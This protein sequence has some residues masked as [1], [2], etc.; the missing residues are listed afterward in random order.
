VPKQSLLTVCSL[1]G[2]HSGQEALIGVYA[3]PDSLTL[4]FLS[5]RHV[6]PG[7]FQIWMIFQL[8]LNFFRR[9]YLCHASFNPILLSQSSEAR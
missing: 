4:R 3:N 6:L 9:M 2:F 8:V 5:I 7:S 1:L